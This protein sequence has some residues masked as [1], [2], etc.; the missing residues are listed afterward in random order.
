MFS[1]PMSIPPEWKAWLVSY[2]EANPPVLPISQIHGFSSFTAQFDQLSVKQNMPSNG[3]Y[4]DLATV[5]PQL[6]KLPKG[7]YV[8]LWGAAYDGNGGA[9]GAMGINVNGT[10]PPISHLESAIIEPV[11]AQRFNLMR[12]L[13]KDLPL[14]VN[15]VKCQYYSTQSP[16][17]AFYVRWLVALKFANL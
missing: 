4:V 14:D 1:D 2:L 17:P 8:F 12:A 7:S 16:G 9:T 13:V 3:S 11:A 15:V 5:G 10:P 6:T